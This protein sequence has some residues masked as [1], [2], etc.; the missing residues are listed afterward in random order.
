MGRMTSRQALATLVA[1]ID[2]DLAL[3]QWSYRDDMMRREKG[4]KLCRQALEAIE[5]LRQ[6]L[7]IQEDGS[8]QL[9]LGL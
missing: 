1:F 2:S 3:R 6:A 9:T 8:E 7:N 4:E 5:H